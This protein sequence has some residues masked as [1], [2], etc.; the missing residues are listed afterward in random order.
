MILYVQLVYAGLH[1]RGYGGFVTL[2]Q[3]R[4]ITEILSFYCLHEL[5]VVQFL[6][7]FVLLLQAIVRLLSWG[8][9]E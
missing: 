6:L 4:L 2:L 1:S 9:L 5:A 8:S 3:K 7:K